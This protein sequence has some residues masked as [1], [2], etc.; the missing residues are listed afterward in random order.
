MQ[1]K[2]GNLLILSEKNILNNVCVIFVLIH[3]Y[4]YFM[5]A[6]LTIRTRS[7]QSQVQGRL[8][9]DGIRATSRWVLCRRG[10]V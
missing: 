8:K 2:T 7:S 10:K 3:K 5:R 1:S 6:M 4:F 9:A